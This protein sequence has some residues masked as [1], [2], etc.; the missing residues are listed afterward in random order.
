MRFDE[1]E[2]GELLERAQH[3][4]DNWLAN[5]ASLADALK[6]N[7]DQVEERLSRLTDA[8]IDRAI[9]RDT[10]E[11]RKAA[12]IAK[13]LDFRER[14]NVIRIGASSVP[15]KVAKFFEL[16]QS[17]LLS[18]ETGF[19]DDKREILKSVTSNLQVERQNVVVKLQNPFQ[20]VASRA[21]TTA[22]G[23]QRDRLRTDDWRL[24]HFFKIITDHLKA[25]PTIAH[26]A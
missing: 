19:P 8:Y 12:L 24:E 18:Y 22:G 16:S 6:L 21:K 20:A 13:R 14:L 25:E 10:F 1:N 11:A 2:L 17:A 7:L 23:P 5:Q 4:K 3:L 15:E 26:D 9:D